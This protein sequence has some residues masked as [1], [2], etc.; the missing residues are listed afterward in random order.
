MCGFIVSAVSIVVFWFWMW[1]GMYGFGSMETDLDTYLKT[2][3]GGLAVLFMIGTLLSLFSPLA[4]LLQVPG[5]VVFPIIFWYRSDFDL[6]HA[7][8]VGL[9]SVGLIG[10]VLTVSSIFVQVFRE[11]EPEQLIPWYRTWRT[12]REDAEKRGR[13]RTIQAKMHKPAIPRT[14]LLA[15]I[16]STLLVLAGFT[17]YTLTQPVSTLRVEALF[18]ISEYGDELDVALYV[19]H[20]FVSSS[21]LTSGD[22]AL[23]FVAETDLDPGKHDIAFDFANASTTLDG[24]WEYATEVRVLPYTVEYQ[25]IGFGVAF[26]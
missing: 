12:T 24:V 2:L 17:T 15:L 8:V 4:S 18:N 13:P 9:Y 20:R 14:W 7:G 10:C 16:A 5:V 11:T 19:D 3:Q 25:L 23:Y 6:S 22:F 1:I 26:I 21:H